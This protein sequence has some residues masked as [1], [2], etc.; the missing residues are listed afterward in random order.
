MKII[1]LA[2]FATLSLGALS[3][4]AAP[5]ASAPGAIQ[6]NSTADWANG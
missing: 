4:N 6:Q 2:L 1:I 5:Y 3:A